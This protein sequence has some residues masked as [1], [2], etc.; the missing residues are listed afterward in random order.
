MEPKFPEEN[1][2]I[3][4][5]LED[6]YLSFFPRPSK[7]ELKSEYRNRFAN[8]TDYQKW[9]RR[10]RAALFVGY[11]ASLV[12]IIFVVRFLCLHKAKIVRRYIHK[13]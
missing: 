7:F 8:W 9:R 2:L 6:F 12:L 13:L 4:H 1:E 3:R 10:K 11:A 5:L